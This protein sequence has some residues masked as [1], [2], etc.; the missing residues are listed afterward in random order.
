MRFVELDGVD[1]ALDADREATLRFYNS[2][3]PDGAYAYFPN[4]GEL[5]GDLVFGPTV[6]RDPD[7][8]DYDWRGIGH[9]LGHAVGL[10][11]GHEAQN[12]FGTMEFDRDSVEFSIMTYRS[13]IGGAPIPG[14]S[15][16]GSSP[17]SL[18]MYD[19][20]ALQFLYG[21]NF[22]HNSGNT[23]YSA[24]PDTGEFFVNAVSQGLPVQT[25]Q[26]F[27]Q[28]KLF[29]TVWD[30]DG[31]DDLYDFSNFTTD[32]I[33]DL[34]PGRWVDLDQDGNA[35]RA[36]LEGDEFARGHIFN[37]LQ[38]EGSARSLIENAVAGTG[39]DAVGGNQAANDLYGNDGRD[40]VFGLDGNDA[41]FGGA[42]NDGL[43]GGL[44]DDRLFGGAG[45]DY[46]E[47]EEGSDTAVL[48][49][50]RAEYAVT[51]QGDE[52]SVSHLFGGG[53]GTDTL[54]RVRFIEFADMTIKAYEELTIDG[55]PFADIL[56]GGL[57]DDTITAGLG[58]DR[59]I[60]G[61]GFDWIE[62]G[63]GDDVVYAG[64]GGDTIWG[65]RG[66]DVLVG[67]SG[68]DTLHG[69]KG[70]DT[71][72]GQDGTDLLFG[73][74]GAD[75]MA[76]GAGDDTLYGGD[77]DDRLQGEAGAGAP[78]GGGGGDTL[79]GQ[80][81][82]DVLE[83]S[84]GDDRAYGGGGDD[85]L[86]GDARLD[87][88]VG[89]DG[90][91]RI[92]GG[93]DDD[94]LKGYGDD[95][96]LFGGEGADVLSG[97]AGDDTAYG[98]EGND[99]LYGDEGADTLFG[100]LGDDVLYAGT[101]DDWLDGGEG[102]D[103]LRGRAGDDWIIGGPGDD[104]I[105]GDEGRD[106]IDY[107]AGVAPLVVALSGATQFI[108]GAGLGIDRISSVEG[109]VAPDFASHIIGD[110]ADNWFKGGAGNDR[111]DGADGNDTLVASSGADTLV[112]GSG[113]DIADYSGGIAPLIV[114]LTGSPQIIDGAGL[115]M[116]TLEGIEGLIAPDF[117]SEL[118]GDAGNN[119]L[120]GGAGN[121]LLFGGDGDDI[122][123]TSAGGDQLDGGAGLDT[124]LV[125]EQTFVE[126]LTTLN[127]IWHEYEHIDLSDG[128][129]FDFLFINALS[130]IADAS[131]TIDTLAISGDAGDT[132]I[133]NG[134][135]LTAGLSGVELFG[136]GRL[137]DS[138]AAG[139]VMVW[140]E[141]EVGAVV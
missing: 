115:G 90:D 108:D 31:D 58:D 129:G 22:S 35:L 86:S 55:S 4:S 118:S 82:D 130:E 50:N 95:D 84:A 76:G 3:D 93:L 128:L 27:A 100:G 106:I 102:A 126:T 98:E 15:G 122:L 18:M 73:G 99:R 117:D 88:L 94:T 112:G 70:D 92:Y 12:G 91:D 48:S 10:S 101:G 69:E 61:E 64:I 33:I 133:A 14:G 141:D 13:I 96:H 56:R 109:F 75:D 32:M 71:L 45:D 85:M 89:G 17:Q 9:E 59:I 8:G 11:H 60:A 39:D 47:T 132:V 52:V 40:F 81:G 123:V 77:D 34:R 41:L 19:I 83:G 20:A 66:S 80:D 137:Y 120:Q 68:D 110:G 54:R 72:R 51:R 6:G 124:I 140:I 16:E 38:F 134:L 136:D 63:W 5:G 23:V 7:L 131:S 111:L 119:W 113:L 135:G 28:G 105:I 25:E 78:F 43:F 36:N 1:D 24:D 139:S 127:T 121:D 103:I 97:G 46:L 2:D 67:G 26:P 44:G 49:G 30:G 79:I 125:T 138:Y 42:G 29:R 114:T 65:N 62:A 116:D 107:S 87:Y 74:D 53:D 21:A 104:R 37:A 57:G